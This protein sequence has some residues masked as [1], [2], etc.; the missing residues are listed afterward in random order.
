MSLAETALTPERPAMP[1]LGVATRAHFAP[2]QCSTRAAD[3]EPFEEPTAQTLVGEISV[4]PDRRLPN[5]PGAG[6]VTC[7]QLVP[8][9]CSASVLVVRV[10][11]TPQASLAEPA[12]TAASEPARLVIVACGV[13]GSAPA[14]SDAVTQALV[15]AH[16]RIFSFRGKGAVF[17]GYSGSAG[18]TAARHINYAQCL[19]PV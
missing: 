13:G 17:I 7:A 8:F 6:V 2:F 5:A 4:T 11:P 16:A 1:A 15:A 3:P 12:L 14:T 10:C 9:Q 19:G 18:P